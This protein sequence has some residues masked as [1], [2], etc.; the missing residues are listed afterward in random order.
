MSRTRTCNR[1]AGKAAA[2]LALVAS[3]LVGSEARAQ[4]FVTIRAFT[5]RDG[6]VPAAG[7]VQGRDG[8]L[9]GTTQLGSERGLGTVFGL[10]EAGALRVS[11]A[12]T[13]PEGSDPFAALAPGR[14][15]AFYGTTALGGPGDPYG[16]GTI[17]RFTPGGAYAALH[18]FSGGDGANPEAALVQGQDGRLYGTTAHEGEGGKGTVFAI[19]TTG[20]LRTLHAFSGSDGDLPLGQLALGPDGRLYGTT[21]SGGAHNNG[22]IFRV[23][24]AGDFSLLF[25]FGSA[26]PS[27]STPRG[28]LVL[29]PDG[30]FYGAAEFGGEHGC[31]AIYRV[32]PGGDFA[33][34]HD[35]RQFEG[36]NPL[37]GLLL[38]GD[39]RLYGT[40]SSGGAHG[41][42]TIF[43]VTLAGRV[44]LLHAFT[45]GADGG[46]PVSGLLQARDGHLYGTTP[47]GGAGSL[48]TV[49]RLSQPKARFYRPWSGWR[50][51]R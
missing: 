27:P 8:T 23:S 32:S 39:G 35:L 45:G 11:Y 15:G 18:F 40:A 41:L 19:T 36:A 46:A 42:G 43:S 50:W 24:P 47:L 6:S 49:Y 51:P 4:G 1:G 21:A 38:G 16:K 37:A 2:A 7:L 17:F 29:A 31:G 5:G 20:E 33:T 30:L 12:L 48:G 25:S 44:S 22:A 9:Y 26:A 3:A 28:G 10:D 13:G 14:D 34:V